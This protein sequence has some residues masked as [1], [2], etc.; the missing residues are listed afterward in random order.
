[1]HVEDQK[2]IVIRRIVPGTRA[3]LE[4]CRDVLMIALEEQAQSELERQ[5]LRPGKETEKQQQKR[6]V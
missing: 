5:S 3:K 4:P 6:T 2:T 1:M